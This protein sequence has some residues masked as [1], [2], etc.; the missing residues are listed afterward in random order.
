[1]EE[2]FSLL[3]QLII[4]KMGTTLYIYHHFKL[5]TLGILEILTHIT[6]PI[7][8]IITLICKFFI[9]KLIILT[10]IFSFRDLLIH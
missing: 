8:F 3:N 10:L 2:N 5:I 7:T 4:H 6:V 9:I 1:L